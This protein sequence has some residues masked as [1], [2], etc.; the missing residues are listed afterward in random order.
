MESSQT[1]SGPTPSVAGVLDSWERRGS[2]LGDT[3]RPRPE[4]AAKV[5][6]AL[7]AGGPATQNELVLRTGLGYALVGHALEELVRA[8]VIEHELPGTST[9]SPGLYAHRSES[10]VVLAGLVDRERVELTVADVTGRRLN[11]SVRSLT[12]GGVEE[13]IEAVVTDGRDLIDR[14]DRSS[15]VRACLAVSADVVR[16]PRR[17]APTIQIDSQ[18]LAQRAGSRLEVGLDLVS[19]A[20]AKALAV[21]RDHAFGE[22]SDVVLIDAGHEL[23]VGVILGGRLRSGAAGRAGEVGLLPDRRVPGRTLAQSARFD[24]GDGVDPWIV[25]ADAA[26]GEPEAVQ[27]LEEGIDALAE[28]AA[29]MLAAYDPSLLVLTGGPAVYPGWVRE[30]INEALA[31]SLPAPVLERTDVVMSALGRTVVVRGLILEC[32]G[33]MG[34]ELATPIAEAHARSEGLRS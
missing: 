17:S 1:V 9:A 11:R 4:V 21:Q 31:R 18:R 29:I 12:G 13:A 3:G 30:L 7:A 26:G 2:H 5:A 20:H 28:V 33:A 8:R 16:P 22:H 19:P 14:L 15:L 25:L 10:R 24:N 32:L 34:L 6:E 27:R 23:G